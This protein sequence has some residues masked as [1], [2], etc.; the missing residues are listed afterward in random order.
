MIFPLR[1]KR[2]TNKPK[3]QRS[4]IKQPSVGNCATFPRSADKG[5]VGR[6][7]R[8]FGKLDQRPEKT[9]FPQ[10]PRG[11][12]PTGSGRRLA[13]MRKMEKAEIH[14]PGISFNLFL[15]HFESTVLGAR[16]NCPAA[17]GKRFISAF[18]ISAFFA[19]FIMDFPFAPFRSLRCGA[20]LNFARAFSS[21]CVSA[22]SFSRANQLDDRKSRF[23]INRYT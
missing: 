11:Q 18:S 6:P 5:E 17:P 19:V 3:M 15:C 7:N 20:G 14:Q 21:V 9:I 12:K 22:F 4:F 8:Q 23:R 16:R 2:S 10:E 13:G 1:L